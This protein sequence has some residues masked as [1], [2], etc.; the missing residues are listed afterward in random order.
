MAYKPENLLSGDEI[1]KIIEACAK[2]KVAELEFGALKLKFGPFTAQRTTP[3]PGPA[4][5]APVPENIL[6]EQTKAQEEALLVE[7]IKTREE[8]IAELIIT[9]P[10]AAEELM[11]SEDYVGKA[12][13]EPDDDGT[14][15]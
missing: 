12:Q 11:Q 6:Q 2:R 15:D 14:G 9:N 4:I 7:E 5:P 13:E 1:C 3:A 8:Q 10:L